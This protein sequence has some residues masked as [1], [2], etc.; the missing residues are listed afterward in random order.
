MYSYCCLCILIVVYVFLSLSMYSY[1][2]LCVVYVFLDAA[3]LPEVFSVLFP[4]LQGKCQGITRQDGARPALFPNKLCC[5]VYCLCVNVYCTAA[6][7]CQP[8]CS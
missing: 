7:G 3:T 4:Q 1:R 2:C 6:T 5:S 8:N